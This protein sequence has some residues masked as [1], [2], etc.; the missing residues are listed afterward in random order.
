MNNLHDESW[1]KKVYLASD[2]PWFVPGKKTMKGVEAGEGSLT[3]NSS[4]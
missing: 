3:E 1:E 2:R 4:T